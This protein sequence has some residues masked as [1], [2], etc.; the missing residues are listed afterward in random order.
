[1]DFPGETIPEYSKWQHPTGNSPAFEPL[2]IG[3]CNFP[4]SK[5][6]PLPASI[7]QLLFMIV[8]FCHCKEI[9]ERCRGCRRFRRK[10]FVHWPSSE[11]IKALWVRQSDWL[12]GTVVEWLGRQ[13]CNPEVPG[14]PLTAIWSCL[15]LA[16]SFDR[17][18]LL[19]HACGILKPHL[20]YRKNRQGKDERLHTSW[21]RQRAGFPHGFHPYLA[22]FSKTGQQLLNV[23][24]KP[25][26]KLARHDRLSLFTLHIL[27]LPCRKWKLPLPIQFILALPI[28]SVV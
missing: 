7:N 2:K 6:L 18:Q 26:N 8:W 17:V 9:L 1:M 10:A 11:R 23:V 16:P 3:L 27:P 5:R 25:K 13:T 20:H 14:P 19:H 4:P 24:P 28:F 22:Y 15:S 12:L 21:N